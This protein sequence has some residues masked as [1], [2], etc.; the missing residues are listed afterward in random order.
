[1]ATPAV[2]VANLLVLVSIVF[3]LLASPPHCGPVMTMGTQ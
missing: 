2:S 3:F 1:M